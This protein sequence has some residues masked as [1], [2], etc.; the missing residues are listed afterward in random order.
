[1]GN[2]FD[3]Y[4]EQSTEK[5]VAAASSA[6]PEHAQ[7]PAPGDG[8]PNAG[9]L[10][11]GGAA[12][13]GAGAMALKGRYPGISRGLGALREFITA[14]PVVGS[15]AVGATAGGAAAVPEAIKEGKPSDLLVGAGAGAATGLAANAGARALPAIKTMM[16]TTSPERAV[17]SSVLADA[18]NAQAASSRLKA[19]ATELR[20]GARGP[21]PNPQTVGDVLGPQGQALAKQAIAAPAPE[22]QA[23]AQQLQQRQAGAPQRITEA[24]NQGL[25]PSP[26][27]DEEQK[28]VATMKANAKPLYD[29]AYAAFPSI[30]SDQLSNVLNN[31]YGVA[32][33]KRAVK[34]MKADGVPIG[35]VNPQG[36]VMNPSLQYFDYVKRALDD[37]VAGAAATGNKNQARIIGGMRDRMVDEIDQKTAGPNGVSPYAEARKQFQSDHAVVD[38][39][40]SGLDEFPK[41]TPHD[42]EAAMTN[43]DFSS[44][45]AFRSGVAEGLFREIGKT[46]GKVNTGYKL[47]G[48]P[49]MQAKLGALFDNPKDAADFIGTLQREAQMYDHTKVMTTS[50]KKG[51]A[52]AVAPSAG[53][54]SSIADAVVH[55]KLTALRLA[56]KAA[57]PNMGGVSSIMSQSGQAGG[58]QLARL[59]DVAARVQRAKQLGAGAGTAA[60]VLGG[61]AAGAVLP[62]AISKQPTE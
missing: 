33:S 39:L 31:P 9:L 53:P 19:L 29:K 38:A 41:M 7:A 26:Y 47:I 59:A 2:Y 1:M 58:D 5:A 52:T 27:T 10:E 34:D 28:L 12:A 8:S 61:G 13:L 55:P 36:M 35:P 22:S 14:H 48:T 57:A 49:D 43:M 11:V 54:I 45:D 44:K 23:Y 62:Q 15:A 6:P 46:P 32:A 20:S 4:D 18:G 40:H 17:A 42:V 3:K 30:Q 50:A 37:Q 25:A 60:T 21:N 24:V 51:P 16:Q 56:A